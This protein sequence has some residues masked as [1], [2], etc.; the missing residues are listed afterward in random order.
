MA[1][2]LIISRLVLA[3]VFLV[4]GI[5]KLADRD[6]S[7][8]AFVDFGLPLQLA[9]P[10]GLLLPL[11]ELAIAMALLPAPSAWY[12]ALGGCAL[13]LVFML[14]IGVTLAHGRRPDCHCFGQVHSEPIGVSTLMRNGLL[15][16]IGGFGAWAGLVHNEPSLVSW[17]G[18]LRPTT[19]LGLAA[20]LTLLA[21]LAGEG[22]LLVEILRQQG[23]FMSRLE[24]LEG[25]SPS[26]SP[27]LPA[28]PPQAGG[29]AVGSPAPSFRLGGLHGETMTLEA[30]Q[31]GGRQLLLVFVHP[32]CGPCQALL[33]ELGRW[34]R[35]DLG[36]LNLVVIGE[37]SVADNLGPARAA[38]LTSVFLQDKREV[39]EAYRIAGT[40]AAVLVDTNGLIASL[41]ALGAEAIRALQLPAMPAPSSPS[42]VPLTAGGLRSANGHLGPEAGAIP[43]GPVRRGELAP[44]L[45]LNDLAGR[46]VT[47]D[48]FRGELLLLLF[49][50]PGCGFC[51][52]MLADLKKWEARPPAGGPKLLIV[53]GGT[54]EAN[55][56][57]GLRSRV[58]LD[59]DFTTGRAYGAGGTPMGVLLDRNGRVASEVAAGAEAVFRLAGASPAMNVGG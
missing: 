2:A 54:A 15:L 13:L 38:G 4:S 48:D 51:Q 29:L 52:G 9:G 17:F 42:R 53:S 32:D 44:A 39:A 50:N 18:D 45:A 16:A 23:R 5:T 43:V 35:E 20:G 22:V 27:S 31:E 7:R 34:Q 56:A 40:P 1:I 57:Q 59:P 19:Q 6:G 8:Q 37:G 41:P 24:A 3:V 55:L 30:L 58:V 25:A 10:F 33:P 49:W 28:P 46:R 36:R 26:A 47:L 11:A 14:A 21:V 12:A